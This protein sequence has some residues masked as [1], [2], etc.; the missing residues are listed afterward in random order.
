MGGDY[1]KLFQSKNKDV[2]EEQV[3]AVQE[4]HT[5]DINEAIHQ[6]AKYQK[7]QIDKI[8][9]EDFK[10]FQDIGVI[11]E[12]FGSIVG[13]MDILTGSINEFQD[14]FH[15]LSDT[16]HQYRDY[17]LRVHGVIRSAKDR[18]SVFSKDSEEM[19][20]RF[21]G[22]DSSFQELE[23][24]IENIRL[25]ASGIESVADQ[26]NLL[27]LNA[28]IEA[29]RAGEAGKG[30]AVVATEVQSLSQEIQQL[31]DRVN[32]SIQMVNSSLSKMNLSVA[33]SKE[34]MVTNLDNTKKIDDDFSNVID[35]TDKIENINLNIKNM[36]S[37]TDA[38]LMQIR[39][40]IDESKESYAKA[41]K[42]IGQ[43]EA[44]TKSKG[45]MYEDINNITKQFEIL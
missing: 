20:N 11:E 27:S 18:V 16:V 21:E 13:N 34:M 32:S 25:C 28:S 33:S 36:A 40:F 19:M 3:I 8:M 10:M 37:D 30:F 38:E 2:R 26:T 23:E 31:V 14:N 45:I 39:D 9:E 29:A 7:K 35:E 4:D 5:Q 15:K 41:E 43:V 1:M 22:L 17:Q 44:N 24:A 42:F 12:E 6:L